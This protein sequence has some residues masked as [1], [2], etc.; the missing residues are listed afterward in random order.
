VVV[1]AHFTITDFM[2]SFT[3]CLSPFGA[4][5]AAETLAIL[6]KLSIHSKPRVLMKQYITDR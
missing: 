6:K 1:I 3:V 4:E 5:Q 2:M